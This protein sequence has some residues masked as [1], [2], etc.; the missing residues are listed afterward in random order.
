MPT[1]ISKILDIKI[2]KIMLKMDFLISVFVLS[3]IVIKQPHY[4]IW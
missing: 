4:I 1:I 2:G 3:V